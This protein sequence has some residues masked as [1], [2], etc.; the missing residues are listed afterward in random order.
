[1]RRT[2]F[3]SIP[4]G[5]KHDPSGR[6]F[7]FDAFYNGVLRPAVEEAGIECRRLDDFTS[8]TL[9]HKTLFSALVASDIVIADLTTGNPNVLYE[10]GVRHALRRARTILI[11][12]G[13][14]PPGDLSYLHVL[15]YQVDGNG[16]V[17]DAPAFVGALRELLQTSVRSTVSDSPLFEF[18]PDLEVVLPSEMESIPRRRRKTSVQPAFAQTALEAPQR[19]RSE[20]EQVEAVV[21]GSG[22]VDPAEYLALLHRYR[23]LSDWDRVIALADE[24]P[25]EL[26]TLEVRQILALALNRRGQHGDQ[27]RAIAIMEEAVA[28]TGGDAETFGILG[29]IYKDGYEQALRSGDAMAAGLHHE[30]SLAF[31]EQ[32]Y[33][34]NPADFYTGINV[35][36]LLLQRNDADARAKL[37]EIVPQVRGVVEERLLGDRFDYWD[38]AAATHLAAIARDWPRARETAQMAIKQAPASWMTMTTRRDLE[39]LGSS[40]THDDD[41]MQ[42]DS[43]LQILSSAAVSRA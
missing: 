24:A 40:F 30:R 29:R 20:L 42:L 16:Y 11:S 39:A 26:R 36:N 21:R 14:R 9:W 34:K 12:A 38:L 19:A 7:D 37:D 23:D 1:M 43:V 35:I 17:A 15:M 33:R 13:E 22:D 31:Y 25:P 18:F 2:C 28:E 3:V 10:L 6:A 32:G 8:G 27:E 4:F 5:I 41:R